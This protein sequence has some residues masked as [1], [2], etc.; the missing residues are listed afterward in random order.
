MVRAKGKLPRDELPPSPL[1]L[2]PPHPI[3][4]HSRVNWMRRVVQKHMVPGRREKGSGYI[5]VGCDRP[6]FSKRAPLAL[7]LTRSEDAK[8]AGYPGHLLR[9]VDPPALQESSWLITGQ[10]EDKVILLFLSSQIIQ[11]I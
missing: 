9:R 7:T 11:R 8:L 10:S 4:L 1:D 5:T 2:L 3:R 6:P